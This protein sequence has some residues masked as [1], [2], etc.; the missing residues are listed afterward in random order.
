[1][2]HVANKYVMIARRAT[3]VVVILRSQGAQQSQ[4]AN[5]LQPIRAHEVCGRSAVLDSRLRE[6]PLTSSSAVHPIPQTSC[7]WS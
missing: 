1:M 2:S 5:L 7:A 4:R 3:Q 6:W